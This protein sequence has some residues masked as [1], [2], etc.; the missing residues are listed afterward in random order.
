MSEERS[1]HGEPIYRYKPV[2]PGWKTLDM[3][4]GSLE[5]INAHIVA[6]V[7]KI[8]TVCH[9]YF[10][11]LVPIYSKEVELKLKKGAAGLFTRFETSKITELVNSHRRNVAKEEWWRLL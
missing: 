10:C 9:I 2:Q 5:A 7:G 11:A 3:S 8:D 6:H 4:G 1:E